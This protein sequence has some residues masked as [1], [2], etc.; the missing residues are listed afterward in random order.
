MDTEA[1]REFQ[2]DV[3]AIGDDAQRAFLGAADTSQYV[4]PW[5]VGAICALTRAVL[6][7]ARELH[8]MRNS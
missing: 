8:G 5:A 2:A 7:V 6:L 4:V 3:A 1:F